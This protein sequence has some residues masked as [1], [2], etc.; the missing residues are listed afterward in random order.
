M[1][2]ED[3]AGNVLRNYIADVVEPEELAIGA[4]RTDEGGEFEEIL[5]RCKGS[6]PSGRNSPPRKPYSS[7]GWLKG[8]WGY[9][10]RES[11]LCAK[12]LLVLRTKN[13]LL[14]RSLWH[15]TSAT[16]GVKLLAKVECLHLR[17]G[18]ADAKTSRRYRLSRWWDFSGQ[19][20][21][22]TSWTRV[23]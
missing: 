11:W 20:V 7:T 1:V 23:V 5:R 6:T 13:V 8:P 4:V 9:C 10:K 16:F 3:Q 21:V 14:G 17:S 19:R 12:V 22:G 2:S 15:A 18:V